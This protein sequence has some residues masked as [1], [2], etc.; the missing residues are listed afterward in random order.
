MAVNLILERTKQVPYFTEMSSV[1][2]ALNIS[3]CDYDWYLSD[4]EINYNVAGFEPNDQWMTGQD[5]YQLVTEQK[6]QFIWGV[7]S[8]VPKGFRCAVESPP[9]A[10]GNSAFWS[11]AE[12][13]PQ[14]EGALFEISSWDSCATILV[15]LGA[16]AAGHFSNVY[17]DAKLL[18]PSHEVHG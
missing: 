15:G 9:F 8:A 13:K 18:K 14:L 1:F 5:L 10:D 16:E 2:E 7:F 4:L 12:C 11:S 6:L 3:A 17:S